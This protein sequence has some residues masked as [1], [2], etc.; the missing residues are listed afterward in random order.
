MT[1]WEP[2]AYPVRSLYIMQPLTSSNLRVF[3]HADNR[4]RKPL[5]NVRHKLPNNRLAFQQTAILVKDAVWERR[6]WCLMLHISRYVHMSVIVAP[7]F[8]TYNVHVIMQTLLLHVS[9]VDRHPQYLTPNKA[10]YIHSKKVC[11]SIWRV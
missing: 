10:S 11:R 1:L 2:L 6:V 5:R 8:C 4:G 7:T 3:K 9:A